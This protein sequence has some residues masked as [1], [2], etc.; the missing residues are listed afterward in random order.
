MHASYLTRLASYA[1]SVK[2]FEHLIPDKEH[3]VWVSWVKHVEYVDMLLNKDKFSLAEVVALDMAV[4]EAMKQFNK[5]PEYKGFF[6]PKQHFA[7]HA[8]INTL[9]M[10]PMRGYA[11]RICMHAHCMT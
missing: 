4:F 6:K 7:S 2:L 8:S 5:V 9:R 10:G 1:H 3:P 11:P